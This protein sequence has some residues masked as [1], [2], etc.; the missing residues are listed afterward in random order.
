[1]A[2]Q[3]PSTPTGSL[4]TQEEVGA[5]FTTAV[6]S[7]GLSAQD[8]SEDSDD[9]NPVLLTA[10]QY[11]ELRVERVGPGHQHLAANT[12]LADSDDDNPV[13]LTPDQF[14]ELGGERVGPGHQQQATNTDGLKQ[15]LSLQYI[16]IHRKLRS[17][18]DLVNSQADLIR[19]Q[20]ATIKEQANTI[21]DIQEEVSLLRQGSDRRHEQSAHSK[22][23]RSRSPDTRRSRSRRGAF[24]GQVDLGFQM[25]SSPLGSLHQQQ[26]VLLSPWQYQKL[27][28]PWQLRYSSVIRDV[29]AKFGKSKNKFAKCKT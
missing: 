18:D 10:E 2:S 26:P 9:D 6:S 12:D 28:A 8:D 24:D 25:Q 13:M 21:A 15:F 20:T 3:T 16:A 11:S 19:V 14:S 4:S 27:Q 17:L 22:R 23:S 5:V 29:L 7:P 1:M